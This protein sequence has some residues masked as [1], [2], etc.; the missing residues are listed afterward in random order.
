MNAT[1]IDFEYALDLNSQIVLR[2]Y[3]DLNHQATDGGGGS[4]AHLGA[5]AVF[6]LKTQRPLRVWTKLEYRAMQAQYIPS[7]F[8]AAYDLQRAYFPVPGGSFTAKASAGKL[9]ADDSGS[10]RHN[11]V[12]GEAAFTLLDVITGGASL[13]GTPGVAQSANLT[14]WATV[15][16]G[17]DLKLSAYF[18]RRNFDTMNEIVKLDERSVLA[19]FAMYR[20]VG[21]VYAAANI[22]RHWQAEPDGTYQ[23]VNEYQLSLVLNAELNPIK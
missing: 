19:V 4:A 8:D 5:L 15:P 18:L 20:L 23:G 2:P 3:L 10:G 21:P 14:V 16:G 22:T 1:G 9:I 13:F 7:Y 17:D 12:L 6:T 11:G